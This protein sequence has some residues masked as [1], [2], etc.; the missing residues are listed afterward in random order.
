[1]AAPEK[2]AANCSRWVIRFPTT[3]SP[4][5]AAR[6]VRANR[7]AYARIRDAGGTLYP[8]SAFP[9]SRQDWRRHFGP[10]FALLGEAKRRFDLGAVLTPG[11]EVF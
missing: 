10:A 9:M 6:L 7:A 2:S 1:M 8:V 4:V 11:Y 3:D 5:E